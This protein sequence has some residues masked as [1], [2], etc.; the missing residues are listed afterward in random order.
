MNGNDTASSDNRIMKQVIDIAVRL[1]FIT[2]IMLWC[3]RIIAPFFVPVVW[4]IIIAV[5]MFPVFTKLRSL[6]GGRARLAGGL[7]ILLSLAVVLV[8]TYML[9][10]SIIG[11]ATGLSDQLQEGTLKIPPPTEKVKDWPLIGEKTYAAWQLASANMESAAQKYASQLKDL[12]GWIAG[13]IA[14]FGVALV[15]TIFALIITGVL[16]IN[17]GGGKR[18][19]YGI[20]RRL[21]D[22]TG[23][24]MVGITSD[25][26]RSVV[27][28]VL[29]VA[30]IQGLMAAIGLVVASVPGAGFIAVL[31]MIVAIMQL[32]PIL[33]L[34]PVAIY[35]FSANDSTVIAVFFLIWSLVISG[36]DGILKPIFLG[37]GVP[38]PMLV[39]LIGAIGGMIS[40][41]IIGLFVGAVILSIGYR[42]FQA[43]TGETLTSDPE[44]SEE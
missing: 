1:A 27:R 33:I 38:I 24:E 29:L 10:D 23:Q 37:R 41:G 40:A 28:G 44:P 9:A 11:G 42:L 16:M 12:G 30:M 21:G 5:A 6:V 4:G 18:L 2:L 39:I 32:P 19:A 35:V 22:D 3:G 26:I 34:G 31:V 8:P 7:F 17:A 15:Q 13:A 36:S 43:W 25:V 14:A 20:G